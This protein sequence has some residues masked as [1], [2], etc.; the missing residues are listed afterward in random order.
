MFLR[1]SIFLFWLCLLF[2][3]IPF[4][5]EP[6]S[7]VYGELSIDKIHLQETI[8]KIGTEQNDLKFGL[9]LSPDSIDLEE[10]NSQLIIASHSGNAKTSYFKNL[11]QLDVQDEIQI[12]RGKIT[13]FYRVIE[14]YYEKK[15]GMLAIKKPLG[16]SLALIT[17]TK[18]KLDL[19]TVVLAICTGK[20][21]KM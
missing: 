21:E 13:Y 2:L 10:E 11:D 20:G 4:S 9:Y 7:S 15:D 3:R 5:N 6:I 17:C 19:Q 14:K 18:N 16:D 1:N 12:Q 8:Y